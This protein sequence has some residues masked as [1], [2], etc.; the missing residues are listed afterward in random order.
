MLSV[1]LYNVQEEKH[2][3]LYLLTGK[4]ISKPL[5]NMQTVRCNV[6]RYLKK[7]KEIEEIKVFSLVEG[8]RPKFERTIGRKG[9]KFL[10]QVKAMGAG[11]GKR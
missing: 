11:M 3:L 6:K 7:H 9:R 2:F 5:S 8:E 10:L 4:L 1:G